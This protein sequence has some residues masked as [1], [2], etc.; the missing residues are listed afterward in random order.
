MKENGPNHA[1][2]HAVMLAGAAAP[3]TVGWRRF[4]LGTTSAK[5]QTTIRVSRGG[6]AR[7][8]V[9]L[10][11][12][13]KGRPT[14]GPWKLARCV[15][16]RT[17]RRATATLKGSGIQTPRRPPM[18]GSPSQLDRDLDA[19]ADEALEVARSMP[20]GPEKIEALKKAGLLR[21]A[22]DAR[23]ITFAKRGRPN[24]RKAPM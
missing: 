20:C 10:L 15:R 9:T 1:R 13:Q 4:Q 3:G 24:T 2:K 6:H 23:G 19:E 5:G 11:A 22:A 16:L 12:K 17:D 21:R 14:N 7:E 18:T 8:S